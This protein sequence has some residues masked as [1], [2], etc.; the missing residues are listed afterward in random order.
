MQL[1]SVISPQLKALG[2]RKKARNWWRLNA[3]TIRV[4]NLQKSSYG[5]RIY[6]N[7]GVYLRE[8]GQEERPPEYRCHIRT[9]LETVVREDFWND[10]ASAESATPPSAALV[11]AVLNDGVAWL[12][13]LSTVDGIR[14]FIKSGGA[15]KCFI[16]ASVE[17][18]IGD[19]N[20]R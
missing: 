15:D 13:Q 1:E 5:E 2:F 12:E 9:R 19:H 17:E 4:I 8:L 18:L 20:A 14:N 11:E 6:I 3:D 10:I 16:L 7:L